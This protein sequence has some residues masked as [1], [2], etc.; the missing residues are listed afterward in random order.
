MN[1]TGIAFFDVDET[2]I[3]TKSMFSFLEFHLDDPDRYGAVERRLRAMARSG[4]AR[5]E[6]NRLYYRSYAGTSRSEVAD[7]GRAWF[8]D[9]SARPGFFHE[10]VVREL[11][12]HQAHGLEVAL[13]SGSFR[14]CLDPVA[15]HLGADHVLCTEPEVVDDRYTGWVAG[16]PMIGAQKA[17]AARALM[18]RAGARPEE[19]HAYG[20][21]V[22]DLPLLLSV[23]NATAV[24]NDPELGE[25]AS[26]HGWLRLRHAV[27]STPAAPAAP[28]TPITK[29]YR[30]ATR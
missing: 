23:G 24:G 19:C 26:R 28:A 14:A 25:H 2:L 12:R 18:S 15:E 6:T 8:A 20:D 9:R 29:E 10:D 1:G 17:V 5:E 27:P 7:S 4:V 30:H 3:G 16:S 13:V 21:H 22:S 11:R